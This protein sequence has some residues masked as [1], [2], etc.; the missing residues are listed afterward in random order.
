LWAICE[1]RASTKLGHTA[2]A[3]CRF[4]AGRMLE[5]ALLVA[6]SVQELRMLIAHL[7]AH[8]PVDASFHWHWSFRRRHRQAEIRRA[9]YRKRRAKSPFMKMKP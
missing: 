7:L 4:E 1:S 2:D 9:H 3:P 5:T 8:R 6:I